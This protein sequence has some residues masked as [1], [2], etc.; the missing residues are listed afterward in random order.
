M[1]TWPGRAS[2][3]LTWPGTLPWGPLLHLGCSGHSGTCQSTVDTLPTLWSVENWAVSEDSRNRVAEHWKLLSFRRNQEQQ[4]PEGPRAG[5]TSTPATSSARILGS[6]T[7]RRLQ[8]QPGA[9]PGP[10]PTPLGSSDPSLCRDERDV[11]TR[12]WFSGL[13]AGQ[14]LTQGWTAVPGF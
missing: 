3:C 5:W 9:G 2:G 14:C 12:T 7:G 4:R 11:A 8:W 10:F 6:V 13:T 1:G